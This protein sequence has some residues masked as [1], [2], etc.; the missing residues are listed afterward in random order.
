M[1]DG[2]RNI[3]EYTLQI[4]DRWGKLVFETNDFN[5]GWDGKRRDGGQSSDGVYF[6]VVNAKGI[7]NQAY[8][9]KGNVTLIK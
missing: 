9:L 7:D 4:F 2:S 1:P 5:T 6:W 8:D 3:I